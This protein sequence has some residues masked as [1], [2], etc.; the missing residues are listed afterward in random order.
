MMESELEA[1]GM[2]GGSKKMVLV[3]PDDI[4]S[5]FLDGLFS[6][7]SCCDLTGISAATNP[8][9]AGF[10]GALAAPERGENCTTESPTFGSPEMMS[11]MRKGLL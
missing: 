4:E 1:G 11:A 9:A 5:V 3:P 6:L 10:W 2:T 8:E 7:G